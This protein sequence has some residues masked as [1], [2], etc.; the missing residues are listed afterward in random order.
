MPGHSYA[1][2]VKLNDKE[3]GGTDKRKK[4]GME[5]TG[6]VERNKRTGK[7]QKGKDFKPTVQDL[8]TKR[9]GFTQA[10]RAIVATKLTGKNIF[11]LALAQEET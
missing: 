2:C 9:L 11:R 1:I 7:R 8:G 6:T 10:G 3:R 4:V 5:G